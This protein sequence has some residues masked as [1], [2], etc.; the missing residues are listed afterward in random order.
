MKEYDLIIKDQYN[1]CVKETIV[2]IKYS[3]LDIINLQEAEPKT[4]HGDFFEKLESIGYKV[5]REELGESE[6]AI[7]YKS[8]LFTPIGDGNTILI[9]DS[10]GQTVGAY[11][12]L[13]DNRTGFI[14]RSVTSHLSGLDLSDIR[15][16]HNQKGQGT[17]SAV[18]SKK[19]MR[20]VG[21][22]QLKAVL[23]A[24]TPKIKR[25]WLE[26][27]GIRK[28]ADSIERSDFII[29]GSD[30]NRSPKFYMKDGQM[31][32][33]PKDQ[34]YDA[35]TTAQFQEYGYTPENSMEATVIDLKSPI[36]YKGDQLVVKGDQ[37]RNIAVQIEGL[38]EPTLLSKAG[39]TMSDHIPVISDISV[40]INKKQ[41]FLQR[42]WDRIFNPPPEDF[43]SR[44][45]IAMDVSRLNS[46]FKR[47]LQ[48]WGIYF[49][50]G[51]NHSVYLPA[52]LSLKIEE[53]GNSKIMNGEENVAELDERN[54][55]KSI[56]GFDSQKQ[57][58]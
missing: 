29:H 46:T 7:A 26:Y 51:N 56:I 8:D 41:T 43:Q 45:K 47:E 6:Y 42:I 5:A 4:E 28:G 50:S 1:N 48:K 9:K 33:L 27:F 57:E 31:E 53:T 17:D 39:K 12:D 52:N 44:K 11:I 19:E 36:K 10:Q 21:R 55:V 20:D 25:T 32:K 22:F 40:T 16:L 2:K 3:E 24:T 35:N 18:N 38:N 58:E 30:T 37:F 13:K 15:R 14:Y 23:D 34:R 49:E 54:N